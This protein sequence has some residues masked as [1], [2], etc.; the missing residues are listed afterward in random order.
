MAAA[1]G[2]G[3]KAGVV[4]VGALA[5]GEDDTGADGVEEAASDEGGD[6]ECSGVEE[7]ALPGVAELPQAVRFK[8]NTAAAAAVHKRFMMIFPPLFV[9]SAQL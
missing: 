3:D 9:R 2:S 5:G 4:S 6:A 7:D 1:A 8:A